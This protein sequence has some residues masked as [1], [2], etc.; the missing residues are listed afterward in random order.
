MKVGDKVL[1]SDGK[2]YEITCFYTQDSDGTCT[3]VDY[4]EVKRSVFGMI[5][6]RGV[7]K[8]GTP[9]YLHLPLSNVKTVQKK[10]DEFQ[11]TKGLW[12]AFKLALDFKPIPHYIEPY[13]LKAQEELPKW[14][15]SDLVPNPS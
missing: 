10:I 8:D 11:K 13:T 4:K 5:A 1:Y 2:Y 14:K 3:V 7:D 9:V 12:S 15:E 6:A